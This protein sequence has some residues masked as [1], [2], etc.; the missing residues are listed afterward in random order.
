MS[1]NLIILPVLFQFSLAIILLFFWKKILAQKLLSIAGSIVSVIIAVVLFS[2]VYEQQI[3]TMQAGNWKAPFGISFV[4]DTFSTTM[5]LLAS[6]SS[7][8]VTVFSSVTIKKA[9]MKKLRLF[10]KLSN[11]MG[12][13]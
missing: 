5:V 1:S 2:Q 4:A 3:L 10:L 11:A 8:A 7:L 9:R 12:N 6:I 13:A